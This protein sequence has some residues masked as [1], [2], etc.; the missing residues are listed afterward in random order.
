MDSRPPMAPTVNENELHAEE[1]AAELHAR[2]DQHYVA[3]TGVGV[4]SATAAR[5]AA[6]PRLNATATKVSR[7]PQS[8]ETRTM[9]QPVCFA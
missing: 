5:P 1:I 6:V 4:G 3:A 7:A 9:H 2:L 8:D